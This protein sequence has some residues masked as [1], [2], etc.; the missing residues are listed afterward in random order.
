MHASM[1]HLYEYPSS[2]MTDHPSTTSQLRFMN[3]EQ[4]C[5]AKKFYWAFPTYELLFSTS[6]HVD[7]PK[8]GENKCETCGIMVDL[9]LF[10]LSLPRFVSS[11]VSQ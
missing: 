7:P 1:L 4:S 8:S 11:Y 10:T 2:T 9:G 5:Q 6:S 3:G